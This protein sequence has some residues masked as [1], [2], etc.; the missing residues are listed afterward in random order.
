MTNLIKRNNDLTFF[1]D[2]FDGFFS[3]PLIPGTTSILRTDIKEIETGYELELDVPG[4]G[5]DDIKIS[6]EKGYLTVEAHKDENKENKNVRYLR[7]ERVY[8]S[9]VRSFFVGDDIAEADIKAGYDKGVLTLFIP[10]QGTNIKEKQYIS[11]E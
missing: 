3:K 8:S 6:L 5:K 9:C 10:K 4:I 2:F 7:Q 11:I 1:D